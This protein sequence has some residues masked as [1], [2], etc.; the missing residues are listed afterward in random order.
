M[1]FLRGCSVLVLGL[2]ASGLAMARWCV[3]HGAQVQV[4]DSRAAPPHAAE[5]HAELPQ[6][7]LFTGELGTRAWRRTMRASRRCW[8]PRAPAASR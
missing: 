8:R 5:L 6:V 1:D 7:R 3:R 2:G 4:W